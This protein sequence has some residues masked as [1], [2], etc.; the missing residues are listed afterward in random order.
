MAHLRKSCTTGHL[1]KSCTSKH[2][3][4]ACATETS[5]T[6]TTTTDPPTT[7]SSEPLTSS[8]GGGEGYFCPNVCQPQNGCEAVNT[9]N[10]T[11]PGGWNPAWNGVG[12]TA[13]PFDDTCYSIGNG[14]SDDNSYTI[15]IECTAP[16]KTWI[17]TIVRTGDGTNPSQIF[18]AP[19]DA[20]QCLH[21]HSWTSVDGGSLTVE[22]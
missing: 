9:V 16:T 8:G 6:T 10:Y 14:G 12:T 1:L 21:G 19:A 17:A 3:L 7:S 20:I 11:A 13:T 5:S 22:I 2:L 15:E 4:K 18:T